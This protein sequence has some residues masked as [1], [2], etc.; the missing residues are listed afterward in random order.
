[1]CVSQICSGV[2]MMIFTVCTEKNRS[3]HA[4][5]YNDVS[6]IDWVSEK[7]LYHHLPYHMDLYV[8]A[9]CHVVSHSR[10]DAHADQSRKLLWGG[11]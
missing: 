7:L 5:E 6:L 10:R 1:V 11:D 8:H 2:K 4:K 9:V 3:W